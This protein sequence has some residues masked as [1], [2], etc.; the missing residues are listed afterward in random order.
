LLSSII[1]VLPIIGYAGIFQVAFVS[2]HKYEFQ[3]Q[4]KNRWRLNGSFTRTSENTNVTLLRG[5]PS[6][7]YPGEMEY[8]LN[9]NSDQSKKI[10]FNLGGYFDAGDSHSKRYLAFWSNM[11]FRPVNSLSISLSPEYQRQN[12]K[13]QYVSIAGPGTDPRYLFGKLDLKTLAVTFRINY[14]INPDL[15]IE[16]YGQP[17]TSAGNYENFSKITDPVAEKFK[18]RFRTFTTP[19]IT[20][21]ASN[22]S[23][24]VDE[25][26]E[27][28]VEYSFNNPDFNFRQFRSNLVIR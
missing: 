12:E 6:F 17:F 23:Y 13:L 20:Y 18:D 10:T 2:T 9:I 22:N 7:I 25:D 28:T 24:D 15:T 16:Y 26:L 3:Y 27:G 11:N 21:D 8:N 1:S 14:T 19:E 5:G 4:F